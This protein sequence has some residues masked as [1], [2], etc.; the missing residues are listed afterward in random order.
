MKKE[1]NFQEQAFVALYLDGPPGVQFKAKQAALG[2]GYSETVAA[3][4]AHKWVSLTTCPVNKLHVRMAIEEGVAERYPNEI[5]DSQWVLKRARLLADFN[6]AKFIRTL[7]NGDAVYDFSNATDDDW[8][9]IEQYATEQ[10]FRDGSNGDPVPVDKLKI[11]LPSKVAALKLV[12]DHVQVQAW[13][14]NVNVTGQITQVTMT[15]DEYKTARA[16]MLN[17]DDC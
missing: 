13:K 4:W 15:A 2:A 9:C 3:C 8:Y 1:L 5:V 6:I 17:D 14:E 7:D 12:G 10:I 11:K 16:E